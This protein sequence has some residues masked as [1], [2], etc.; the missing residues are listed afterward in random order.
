MLIIYYKLI[1][2]RRQNTTGMAWHRIAAL[3]I[4]T[5]LIM[6][7]TF[8]SERKIFLQV[9]MKLKPLNWVAVFYDD[10][11]ECLLGTVGF[12]KVIGWF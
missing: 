4:I 1:L 8:L 11:D 6:Q 10:D 2:H 3:Y 9:L 5:P 12:K 7:L